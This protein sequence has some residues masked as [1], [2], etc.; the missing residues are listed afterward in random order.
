MWPWRHVTIP[1][2]RYVSSVEGN[3]WDA[4]LRI[5]ACAPAYHAC[6]HYMTGARFGN[7]NAAVINQTRIQTSPMANESAITAVAAWR[8]V[9]NRGRWIVA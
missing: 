5:E 7:A 4:F 3:R 8:Q 2:I 1:A 6:K 9:T